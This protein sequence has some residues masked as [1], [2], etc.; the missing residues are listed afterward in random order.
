MRKLGYTWYPKDWETSE[1]VFELKLPE[2]A[3]F[4][5]LIDKAMLS[6]NCILIRKSVW[7]RKWWV[8]VAELDRILQRLS[9]LKLIVVNDNCISVPSCE[10]RLYAKRNG[11]LG[12]A[13]SAKGTAS[14]TANGT[15]KEKIKEKKYIPS[16]EEFKEYAYSKST[17][18]G[19]EVDKT[20]LELKY[21]SWIEN[22]WK[23]GFNKPIKNWK[24]KLLNTLPHLLKDTNRTIKSDRL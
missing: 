1:S 8:D 23:D 3:V 11:K 2:R 17:S 13:S 20:K 12:G 10:T 24:S 16:L 9:D 18:K 7:C 22:G 14:G 15:P 21:E 4:R 5:E 6:D 19:L